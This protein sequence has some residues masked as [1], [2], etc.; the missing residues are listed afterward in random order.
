MKRDEVAAICEVFFYRLQPLNLIYLDLFFCPQ[1]E[2]L[3]D[4]ANLNNVHRMP[5][6]IELQHHHQ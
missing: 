4:K 6:S 3:K 1:M 5:K 2:K